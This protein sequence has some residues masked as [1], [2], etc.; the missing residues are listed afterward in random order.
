MSTESRRAARLTDLREA[1]QEE[2]DGVWPDEH[3]ARIEFWYSSNDGY[4]K[5]QVHHPTISPETARSR[6]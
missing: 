5:S 6:T 3:G 1:W 4:W 2:L